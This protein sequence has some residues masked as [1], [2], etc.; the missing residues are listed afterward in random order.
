MLDAPFI[1]TFIGSFI[2]FVVIYYNTSGMIITLCKHVFTFARVAV[3]VAVAA[4]AAVAVADHPSDVG[5]T[6][7]VVAVVE[8]PWTV[9][10][11]AWLRVVTVM[12]LPCRRPFNAQ[13]DI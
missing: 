4:A 7:A 2:N 8:K 13:G 3:A 9:A 5:A 1:R 10:T 11:T 12:I 6:V